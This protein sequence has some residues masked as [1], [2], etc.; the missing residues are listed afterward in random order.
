LSRGCHDNRRLLSNNDLVKLR[1][2]PVP[3]TG[4]LSF[5]TR[6]RFD[7]GWARV[8]RN[9]PT[10]A[11]PPSRRAQH[12]QH[13]VRLRRCSAKTNCL[14]RATEAVHDRHEIGGAGEG[15]AG[16]RVTRQRA[17]GSGSA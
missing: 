17:V 1:S 9:Q 13:S 2:S 10:W 5:I 12:L 14:G 6:C 4:L 7:A 8:E 11:C 15:R 16:P 3:Q